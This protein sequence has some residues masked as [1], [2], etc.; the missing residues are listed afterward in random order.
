MTPEEE[1]DYQEALR[2]IKEAEKNKSVELDL[3]GL[4][5]LNSFPPELAS[6][7]SLHSL[8]LSWCR[9][10]SGDLSP[11][12]ELTSL[13]SLNLSKCIGI[14][15]FSPL[16]S[17][18]PTLHALYLYGCKFVGLPSEVCGSSSEENV[19]D[20]SPR[21]LWKRHRSNER[22]GWPSDT[23]ERCV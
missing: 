6:L 22:R 7:T 5:Y 23:G 11:L 13:Q 10:L 2:R 20:K 18:L 16:E 19:L 17:L 1:R 9:Q 15:R 3:G 21:S 8:D 12:A 14:R 4:E